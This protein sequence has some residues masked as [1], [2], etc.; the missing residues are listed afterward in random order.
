[1][2]FSNRHNSDFV[3]IQ[4][5][6]NGSEIQFE[7]HGKFLGIIIDTK[8]N[9]RQHIHS[10]C[11]KVSK[12]IGIFYKLKNIFPQ[13]ILINLCY[14]LI[15][16]YFLYCIVIWG[17]ASASNLDPVR[18]LQKR[19]IRLIAGQHYLANTDPLFAG[20]KILKINDIY[21]FA[22]AQYMFHN[23]GSFGDSR[24][25]PYPTRNANQI[26][27]LFQILA[28]SQRSINYIGPQI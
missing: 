21:K 27:P 14:A 8:L 15:Y 25:N 20:L 9:H 17:G 4:L 3:D 7:C 18:K 10:I 2:T 19:I 13:C 23:A 22:I 24:N 1:M 16:P 6:L 12:S 11:N 28:L 5:L 26:A